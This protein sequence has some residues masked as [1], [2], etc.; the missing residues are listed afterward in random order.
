MRQSSGRVLVVGGGRAGSIRV[1]DAETEAWYE[2]AAM[3]RHPRRRYITLNLDFDA[4]PDVIRDINKAPFASRSFARVYFENVEWTSF[5]GNNL[6]AINESARLL[7]RRQERST[8][9][10]A[11][12]VSEGTGF[13]R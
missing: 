12:S 6:G 1:W 2:L 3:P 4:K 9:V 5:T 7:L 8:L 11:R 13:P 10:G